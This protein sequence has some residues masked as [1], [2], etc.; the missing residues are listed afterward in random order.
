MSFNGTFRSYFGAVVVPILDKGDGT[1]SN[2]T[3]D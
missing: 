1:I 2:V 3:H